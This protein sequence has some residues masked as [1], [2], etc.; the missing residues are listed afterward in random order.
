MMP[1]TC[2]DG[3]TPLPAGY[4]ASAGWKFHYKLYSAEMDW[5]EARS[6]CEGEGAGL[7]TIRDQ[8]EFDNVKGACLQYFKKIGLCQLLLQ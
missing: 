6:T 7:A 1:G 8:A 4:T 3:V 2:P 5:W